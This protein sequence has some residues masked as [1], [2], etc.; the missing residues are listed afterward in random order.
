VDSHSTSDSGLG[1]PSVSTER[2][3]RAEWRSGGEAQE[4]EL[5]VKGSPLVGIDLNWG[6]RHT[7]MLGRQI[8]QSPRRRLV[9]RFSLRVRSRHQRAREVVTGLARGDRSLRPAFH[10]TPALGAMRSLG[11][12]EVG[13]EFWL[14]CR[15]SF[16]LPEIRCARIS[17]AL[18]AGAIPAPARG[19][20]AP[21]G[22]ESWAH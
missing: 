1:V 18:S 7:V 17:P 5:P 6:Q 20:A 12:Y 2:D 14:V 19:R 21:P 11:Q 13:F 8:R 3:P 15:R 4:T 16:P 10:S 9:P 22:I